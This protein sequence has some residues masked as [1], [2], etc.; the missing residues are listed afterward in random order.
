MYD[1]IP[2]AN[3]TKEMVMDMANEQAVEFVDLQFTDIYGVLKAVSIPVH[4]LS[5]AITNNVW[6]DGSS[7]GGFSRV[8]ESDMYLK[9]DL[10]TFAV[11][12]WTKNGED[13]TA[14]LICDVFLP[15]GTPFDGDPRGILKRQLEEAKKLGFK[16]NTGPEL[17]FFLLKTDE[18][19][20]PT[21]ML[22]NDNAGYF[23]LAVDKAHE[24]RRHM[25]FALDEMGMEVETLHHEVAEGQH[26]IC[27]KYA[28]ALTTADNAITLKLTVKKIAQMYGLHATFMPKPIFGVAGTGMHVHQSLMGIEDGENKFYD[29]DGV[30]GMSKLAQCYIAGQIKHIKAINALTNPTVNSYKRLVVGYEAPVNAAWGQHNRSALI[31]VPRVNP[32]Q[33]KYASRC[34]LRCPDPSAN[35]YLAFAAMLAAGLDGIRKEMECPDPIE[36]NIWEL[37]PKEMKEKGVGMVASTLKDALKA[38]RDNEVIREALGEHFFNEFYIGKM[39]EWDSYRTYV[40]QWELD[41]YL[42]C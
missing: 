36:D 16:L 2:R 40:T 23:D 4:K 27:F 33:A 26:E 7:I 13:V 6:F 8:I 11:L 19:G 20:E 41:R 21:G 10:N 42:H 30:Y 17:E 3:V 28:D 31:R 38:L 37:T 1:K 29:P 35:P 32:T 39:K 5:D 34:E 22:P 24:V 15:D 9:P 18:N 12:P 14:R 25:A